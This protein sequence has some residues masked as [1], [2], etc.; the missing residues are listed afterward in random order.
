MTAREKYLL[1]GGIIFLLLVYWKKEVIM[2]T[3][4]GPR[5]IR[6]NNPGNI[7]HGEKWQGMAAEQKDAAFVTFISPEYGIRAMVKL[8]ASYRDRYGLM[9]ISQIIGRYA[10]PSENDTAAYIAAVS[11]EID[12]P[13]D[14]RLGVDDYPGFIAAVI[15]HENG[16]QPYPLS[17]I[18]AG[19][20]LAAT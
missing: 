20:A 18:T 12:T 19:I 4:S 7:R 11:K 2:D 16:Q 3:I 6:N 5:G 9:S 14:A 15:R 13:K 17:T 8:F 10:P 1:I